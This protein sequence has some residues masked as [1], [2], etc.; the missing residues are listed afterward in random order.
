MPTD[1]SIRHLIFNAEQLLYEAFFNLTHI[2]CVIHNCI[3]NEVYSVF[4][5]CLSELINDSPF[6]PN[7]ASLSRLLINASYSSMFLSISVP[8]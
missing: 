1:F 5:I 3:N 2:F 8:T 6:A 4:F 7:M